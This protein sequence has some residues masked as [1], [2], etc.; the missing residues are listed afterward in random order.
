MRGTVDVKPEIGTAYIYSFLFGAL[1][2]AGA[3]KVQHLSG[4]GLVLMLSTACGAMFATAF[5]QFAY[6][7]VAMDQTEAGQSG[8]WWSVRRGTT[9]NPTLS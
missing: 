9:E 2:G 3:A 8:Y 4:L 7:S 1:L 6:W 5:G